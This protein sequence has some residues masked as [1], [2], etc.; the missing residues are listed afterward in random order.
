MKTLG[1]MPVGIIP[2][3]V[4]N[5]NS[6]I[7]SIIVPTPNFAPVSTVGFVLIRRVRMNNTRE[8]PRL[9]AAIPVRSEGSWGTPTARRSCS[10][11]RTP[12]MAVGIMPAVNNPIPR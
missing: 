2:L 10:I 12:P 7:P 1:V 9:L 4:F 11:T 5:T 8:I 3:G 6:V